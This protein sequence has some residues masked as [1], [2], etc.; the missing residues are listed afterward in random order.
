M[1]GDGVSSMIF[2]WRRWMEHSRSNKMNDIPVAVGQDLE[3]HVPRAFQIFFQIDGTVA[4]GLFASL[5]AGQTG[6]RQ[7]AAD[8]RR[9]ASPCRRLRPRP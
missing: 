8:R 1:A 3:L 5:V 2:W 7:I 6:L 4:E 9:P